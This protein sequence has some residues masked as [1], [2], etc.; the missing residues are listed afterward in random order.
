MTQT[1][2]VGGGPAGLA[3]AYRLT[4][5]SGQDV[6]LIEKD[7][8]LGG[9]AA[10]FSQGDY[11]LDFGPHRLHASTDPAVLADLR[12]LLGDELEVRPR[13]GRIRLGESFF[14]YPV[15]PSSILRLGPGKALALSAGVLA[16]RL[17]RP[18]PSPASYETAITARLGEPFYRLFYGPYAEKVWGMSG[19]RIAADQAERRV[20]Q[21]GLTDLLRLALGRNTSKYYYYPRGGFGR[22][23]GAFAQALVASGSARTAFPATVKSVGWDSGGVRTIEYSTGDDEARVRADHLVWTAPLAELIRLLDPPAPPAIQQAIGRLR[24]RA[25]VLCYV[26]LATPCVGYAD[27]YYFPERRYPFNR[28][29]EQKNFSHSLVPSD[30]TVLCLDLACDAGDDLFRASDKALGK[31]VLPALEEVGLADSRQ[32]VEVFSRRFPLAYPVYDLDYDACLRPALDW[33]G[34]FE[35][36]WLV[37]RHGLFLHNNTHH[38]IQMGYHAADAIVTRN[39]Q[40]WPA[41][42]SD[43]LTFRVAD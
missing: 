2:I 25:V 10:G 39:R 12:Q 40:R 4:R 3:A 18:S 23:P 5:H 6:L 17:A 22:I 9:L 41:A 36:L 24:H 20:N 43:F 38:S 11:T 16:S 7:P 30:R 33:L 8:V 28:V 42:V 32:V 31:L 27:T 1:V 34:G 37:G 13:M 19:N 15:G 14:P 26:V 29:T 35:N 21:R